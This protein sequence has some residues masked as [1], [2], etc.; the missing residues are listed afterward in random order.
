MHDVQR[1]PQLGLVCLVA[2]KN[3]N[4]RVRLVCL[5]VQVLC[6]CLGL[7]DHADCRRLAIHDHTL[8]QRGS[9][10]PGP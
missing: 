2:D 8:R 9:F 6:T 10:S 5:R 4:T 1:R 7:F 3:H